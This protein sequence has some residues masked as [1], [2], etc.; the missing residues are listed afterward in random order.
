MHHITV[1]GEMKCRGGCP[2]TFHIISRRNR[3]PQNPTLFQLQNRGIFFC[4]K[5]IKAKSFARQTVSFATSFPSLKYFSNEMA[6]VTCFF[7]S[8][9]S[10]RV[11]FNGYPYPTIR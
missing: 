9:M 1:A 2:I 5:K 8:L 3:G 6:P 7:E 11:T 10:A 4:F